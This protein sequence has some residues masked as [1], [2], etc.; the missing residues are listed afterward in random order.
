MKWLICAITFLCVTSGLALPNVFNPFLDRS[1]RI[2]GGQ[3]ATPG[4]A[5]FMIQ[6][7]NMQFNR[8]FCGGAIINNWWGVTAAHCL[9]HDFG[10]MVPTAGQ[11]NLATVSGNEQRK[12]IALQIVHPNYNPN[13]PAG[14]SPFDIA[15]IRFDSP[16][17]FNQF[18]Q[19]IVLPPQ[20]RMHSGTIRVFGWGN[21]GTGGS[22]VFPNILQANIK[23][24]NL[25]A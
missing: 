7:Q 14:V 8:H 20:D 4:Q 10:T 18:V 24:K 12:N 19:P 9:V 5:P 22:T 17:V 11:H 21:T 23:K 1:G 2:I 15:L 25:L 16:L 3:D 6:L 13:H